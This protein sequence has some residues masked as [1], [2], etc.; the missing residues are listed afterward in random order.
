MRIAVDLMGGD[1]APRSILLGVSE[2]LKESDLDLKL[3]GDRD[4]VARE[5]K[6]L[7]I[8]LPLEINHADQV[9]MMD[10]GSGSVLKNKP[11]A[12]IAVSMQLLKEG[13]VEALVSAGNSGATMAVGMHILGNVD[14]IDRPALTTHFPTGS[15][16]AVILDIGANVDSSE[17]NLCQFAYMGAAYASIVLGK[18]KPRVALLSNGEEDIKGTKSVRGAHNILKRADTLNYVGFLEG[19][20]LFKDKADV[21]VCDGFIGNIVLKCSEAILELIL[22]KLKI[23]REQFEMFEENSGNG[24]FDLVKFIKGF[25]YAELGGAVL[26]GLNGLSIVCHGYSSPKAIKKAIFLAEKFFKMDFNARFKAM[27]REFSM[28]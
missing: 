22:N 16:G 7:N 5:L 27:Y 21:F 11:K 19:S 17:E 3:V 23:S 6:R 2:A 8:D 9:A 28:S 24:V 4:T 1:R 10:E 13:K 20:H 26:L 25:D 15:G 12:S 18:A 14:G